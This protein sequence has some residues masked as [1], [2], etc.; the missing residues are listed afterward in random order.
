[1]IIV[2]TLIIV[3]KL[4][5]MGRDEITF[6]SDLLKPVLMYAVL[7]NLREASTRLFSVMWKSKNMIILLIV[8]YVL[9]GWVC[10]RLFAGTSQGNSLFADREQATWNMMTVFAGANFMVKVLP[11]YGNNRL[12]GILFLGFN[13][14]GFLFFMNLAIAILYNQYLAQVNQ[15]VT[16]FK[17]N[18]ENLLTEFFNKHSD[19]HKILTYLQAYRA[20]D[21][22]RQQKTRGEYDHLSID[23]IIKV[24]DKRGKG[25]VTYEKFLEL[26]DILFLLLKQEHNRSAQ[27][28]V[29]KELP[30]CRKAVHNIYLHKFYEGS[31]YM[32]SIF[33]L[34]ML[35]WREWMEQYG[36]E[37]YSALPI[38]ISMCLIINLVFLI[39]LIFRFVHQGFWKPLQSFYALLEIFFQ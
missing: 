36:N 18:V 6:I 21:E 3:D 9:F 34:G 27:K 38:W 12:V 14:I 5:S 33:S 25:I 20:I 15:R 29:Q 11:A 7:R 1:M 24:M 23:T 32:L 30:K 2:V 22:L 37:Y 13:I 8:Y 39:D 28:H 4:I 17:L 16:K 31:M 10:T 26:F 35:F 19:D